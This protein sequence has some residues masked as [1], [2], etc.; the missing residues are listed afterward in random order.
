M[1]ET[2]FRTLPSGKIVMS[3]KPQSPLFD[4]PTDKEARDLRAARFGATGELIPVV[5]DAIRVGFPARD[6]GIT[7]GMK[8]MEHN[9]TT[10]CSASRGDDGTIAVTRDLKLLR[11]SAGPLENAAV[12]VSVETGQRSVTFS[13]TPVDSQDTGHLCLAD[14]RVYGFVLD[15]ERLRG[16]LVPLGTRGEGGIKTF[17]IPASWSVADLHVYVFTR[18]RRDRVA[19]DTAHAYPTE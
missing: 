8:F 16:R 10:L 12:T 18:R 4:D 3:D 2:M 9:A 11:L 14:D 15:G 19:S 7:P 13:L 17:T 5:L 6:R 1:G